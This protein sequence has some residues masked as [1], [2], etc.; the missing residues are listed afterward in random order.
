MHVGDVDVSGNVLNYKMSCDLT[1]VS[2]I[3]YKF[4]V[5][6]DVIVFE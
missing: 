6:V 2:G 5:Q 1:D 4:S 3:Q